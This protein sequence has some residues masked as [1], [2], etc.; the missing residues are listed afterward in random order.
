M[1]RIA[2]DSAP[3]LR[4][5]PPRRG[6]RPVPLGTQTGQPLP[7]TEDGDSES[8]DLLRPKLGRDFTMTA[9]ANGYEPTTKKLVL[10][11]APRRPPRTAM[12]CI[13]TGSA[14]LL[15]P[16]LGRDLPMTAAAT[17]RGRPQYAAPR[18]EIASSASGGRQTTPPSS[19]A[20]QSLTARLGDSFYFAKCEIVNRS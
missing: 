18:A 5:L 12:L 9:T 1:L 19:S 13:A 3:F 14:K 15:H 17:P 20:Q 8:R 10:G 11:R 7:Q 16:T 4:T 6:G 2:T